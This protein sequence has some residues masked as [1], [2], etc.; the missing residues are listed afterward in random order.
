MPGNEEWC[1]H[2][3]WPKDRPV[4]EKLEESWK[5]YRKENSL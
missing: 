5:K 2:K 4:E 1:Q 3:G